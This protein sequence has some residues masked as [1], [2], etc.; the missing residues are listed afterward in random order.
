MLTKF[1]QIQ[2]LFLHEINGS[3][4][5]AKSFGDISDNFLNK[6]FFRQD[7]EIWTERQRDL[8]SAAIVFD[9][10]IINGA[11]QTSL[12]IQN[13]SLPKFDTKEI[14]CEV[15]ISNLKHSSVVRLFNMRVFNVFLFIYRKNNRSITLESV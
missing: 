11:D 7:V 2:I 10:I 15:I 8:E 13:F 9:E 5:T 1:Y 14:R 6:L 12:F 3:N 4:E